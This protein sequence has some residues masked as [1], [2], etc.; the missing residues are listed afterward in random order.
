MNHNKISARANII[1]TLEKIH[2]GQSLSV[3]LDNLLNGIKDNEKA[4]AHELLLGTLRQWFA[5][6]RI[7]ESLIKVPPTDNAIICALNMGL[8]ELLYMNTADYAVLNETINALKSL[9]KNYGTGLVNAILRK[10]A[11]DKKKYQKKVAK[12]HSLP[13]WL[14]KQIK[15]DWGEYY[16][17]LGQSLRQP[18]PVFIRFHHYQI[19]DMQA[20]YELQGLDVFKK[21][22]NTTC[23]IEFENDDDTTICRDVSAY[24][25]TQNITH[26]PIFKE[27]KLT[28]QDKHAQIAGN[29]ADAI[30]TYLTWHN[31]NKTYHL[32]DA[33][34]APAGKLTH[35]LDC[36]LNNEYPPFDFQLTAIDND[37]HRLTRVYENIK[38]LGFDGMLNNN[39][40][41]KWAD[42]TTFKADTLFDVIML[43]APCSATGVMR[44]HPDIGLLRQPDDIDKIVVLQGQIL[45]NLWQSLVVG[46]YLLYIT[47]SILKAENTEQMTAFLARHDNA[48][49]IKL[50]SHQGIAQTVGIQ[51]LP[52]NKDDGDGFYYALLQKL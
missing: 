9:N 32:L 46:G 5:M 47:C 45:D 37:E 13:N 28:I 11:D 23:C 34:T 22:E 27:G 14:A 10:V 36:L 49:E 21:Q 48:K 31:T 51:Y 43:D 7:G 29:I 38:R 52:L 20:L 3:L 16:E 33:C 15:Q 42:A 19:G 2:Q 41:I 44:R 8:Y 24:Q 12:N 30:M 25:A 26:L 35:W 1:L 17:T 40:H 4:F 39:L 18:A 6:S 50:M